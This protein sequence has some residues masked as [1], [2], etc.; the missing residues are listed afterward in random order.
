MTSP[1]HNVIF[2]GPPGSSGASQVS[3][4]SIEKASGKHCQNL[5]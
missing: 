5:A 3:A 4:G 2:R 1:T